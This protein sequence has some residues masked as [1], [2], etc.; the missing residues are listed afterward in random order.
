MNNTKI[1]F[2]NK[3][4]KTFEST[5]SLYLIAELLFVQYNLYKNQL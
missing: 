2:D 5:A 4:T 1:S 3:S